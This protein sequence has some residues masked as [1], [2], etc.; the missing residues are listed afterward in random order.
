MLSDQDDREWDFFGLCG[1]PTAIVKIVMRIAR[2]NTARRQSH[3]PRDS[4]SMSDAVSDIV[5]SLEAWCHVPAA[6]SLR[7]EESMHEDRDVLHCS[8]MWRSGLLLYIFRVFQWEPGARVPIHITHRARMVVDHASACRDNN[9]LS[10]QALLPLFF[11]GC[12]LRDKST[13]AEIVRLCSIWDQ[14]TKYHMFR[15]AIP[16][17]EQV[18]AA[19][20]IEGL[21]NV[22]W[23]QV[24]DRQHSSEVHPLKMRICFG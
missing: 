11:A 14:R 24:I 19:L 13:Q 23:G 22:W 16:M 8:E 5:R 20:E 2:L 17:L 4:S 12:E 3:A 18:W 1:C 10:R 7:D 21:E 9:M 15:G 6:T